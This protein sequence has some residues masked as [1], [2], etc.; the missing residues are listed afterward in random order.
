[1]SAA[2]DLL[3]PEPVLEVDGLSTEFDLGGRRIQAVKQVSLT[4]SRG[5]ILAIV[6]ESGSGKS[7]LLQS[8]L[9][10]IRG[11]PGVVQ[12]QVTLRVGD[13][14]VQPFEG[15]EDATIKDA[16]GEITGVQRRWRAQVERRYAGLRGSGV[17]LVLQNGRAALNPFWTVKKHLEFAL[18]AREVG[19]GEEMSALDWLERLGFNHPEV[20]AKSHPHELSGGMAQRAMLAVVLAREPKLLFLDEITT[21]LDVSLQASVLK[22][23]RRL[24]QQVGFSALLIT[25]DLGIARGISQ[26]TVIM[27]RGQIVQAGDTEALFERRVPLH[28]YTEEL[29][30]Q[31]QVEAMER[32][33]LIEDLH[34]DLPKEDRPVVALTGVRKTFASPRRF[35]TKPAPSVVAL[36][37]ANLQIQ[38]AE[39]VALVGESGSGKTTLSRIL[40]GLLRPDAGALHFEGRDVFEMDSFG[41]EAFRR[42]RTILF[43]NPYTSLNP[44]MTAEEVVAEALVLYRDISP[45]VAR[46][47]AKDL[48][49]EMHLGH[50][51]RQ[52]L[53][54]L[55]GGERRRVG[56]LRAMQSNADLMVLDEPTAG[57]DSVH[58][59]DVVKMIWACRGHRPERA[60]V[61]VSHDLGFVSRVAD[62]IVVMYRGAI[63]EDVSVNDFLNQSARHHPYTQLLWDASR[64]VGGVR[65]TMTMPPERRSDLSEAPPLPPGSEG[66]LYRPRCPIY[67]NAPDRWARCATST[68]KLLALSQR[69][70]VACHG[71][72]NESTD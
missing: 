55:S 63:V 38:P 45:K 52:R 56:L 62:R 21:G 42:R 57:L 69:R 44:E 40:V 26:R 29:L 72:A 66:C 22:L 68:P 65:P 31:G 41:R 3:L 14:V 23:L 11:T 60:L 27:R 6:G 48:L 61:I 37:Q 16:K 9:G 19:G 34:L 33:D 43:Q 28:P 53:A 59:R 7:V 35:L 46:N 64:Y 24:H 47:G 67:L 50:R 30:A 71:V 39:S 70:R 1:M 17:G 36:E 10:L 12:G 8:I 54:N 51:A 15:I 18:A 58:R 5:E 49:E 32:T 25:H 13:Q 4:V 20:V 2:A